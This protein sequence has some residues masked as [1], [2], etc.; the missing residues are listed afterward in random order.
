MYI[1]DGVTPNWFAHRLMKELFSLYFLG[2]VIHNVETFSYLHAAG[3][4]GR[5]V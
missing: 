2:C 5:A 3:P 1:C 4:N